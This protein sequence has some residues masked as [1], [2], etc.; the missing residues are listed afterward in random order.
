[1]TA[2]EETITYESAI[3]IDILSSQKP[4]TTWLTSVAK[5]EGCH[6]KR[7]SYAFVTDEE[8]LALNQQFLDHDTYTDI[9]TFPYAYDPIEADIYISY[10]RVKDNAESFGVD[11]ADEL[12]RVMVHGLLH[13]CGYGDGSDEEK[14]QM[15]S[16][17]EHYIGKFIA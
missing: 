10:D 5:E 7:I 3:P 6:I 17:E 9:L 15:R 1:M 14:A 11:V 13:M 8:L 12:L 2:Q 4:L 16:R